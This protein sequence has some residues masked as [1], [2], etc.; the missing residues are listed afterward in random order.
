MK[1]RI[2]VILFVIALLAA[3]GK[4]QEV[5]V[6]ADILTQK[7]MVALLIDFHLAETAI[8]QVQRDKGDVG[9]FTSHYY[10]SI[11]KKH[12]TD[13]GQFSRSLRFYSHNIGELVKIYDEVLT[14]LSKKQSEVLSVKSL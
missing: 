4:T 11:L 1:T 13:R 7:Q 8:A 5:V 12:R 2:T 3:C 9:H 10:N 6:P 14:E